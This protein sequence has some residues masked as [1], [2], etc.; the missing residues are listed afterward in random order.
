MKDSIKTDAKKAN[1]KVGYNP[2]THEK[3][4]MNNSSKKKDSDNEA[5]EAISGYINK[6][7]C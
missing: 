1:G 5:L 6:S 4:Q 3:A 7:D 2:N